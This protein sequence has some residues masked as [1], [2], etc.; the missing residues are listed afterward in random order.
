MPA[1]RLAEVVN[2]V[3]REAVS[4]HDGQV[5][6]EVDKEPKQLAARRPCGQYADIRI[7]RPGGFDDIRIALARMRGLATIPHQ[8]ASVEADARLM[9]DAVSELSRVERVIGRNDGLGHA[10]GDQ[11]HILGVGV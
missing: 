3:G 9:A 6:G 2:V 10:F 5:T 4:A 8:E 11:F 1:Q 7:D